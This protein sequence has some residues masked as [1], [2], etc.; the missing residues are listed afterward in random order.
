MGAQ[1][2]RATQIKTKACKVAVVKQ[3]CMSG[4]LNCKSRNDTQQLKDT[5]QSQIQMRTGM[6]GSD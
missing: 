5:V 1:T 4:R 2:H 3:K 6:R